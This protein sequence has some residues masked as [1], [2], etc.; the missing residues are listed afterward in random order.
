M[1]YK[2]HKFLSFIN[3]IVF[4]ASSFGILFF[5]D[6]CPDRYGEIY[7]FNSIFDSYGLRCG[8]SF[9][10]SLRLLAKKALVFC[11]ELWFEQMC[12]ILN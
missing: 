10:M 11:V 8:P 12:Q 3:F 6:V 1:I 9:W 7:L 5:T 4:I 2:C